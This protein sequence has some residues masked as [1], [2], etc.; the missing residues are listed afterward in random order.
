MLWQTVRQ[1]IFPHLNLVHVVSPAKVERHQLSCLYS[2]PSSTSILI[3]TALAKWSQHVHGT[4]KWPKTCFRSIVVSLVLDYSRQ[5]QRQHESSRE[6]RSTMKT[7]WCTWANG[8]GVMRGRMSIYGLKKDQELKKPCR[9]LE[10]VILS[11][12][13]DYERIPITNKVYKVSALTI[14]ASC[15][16][17]CGPQNPRAIAPIRALRHSTPRTIRPVMPCHFIID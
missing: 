13:E 5:T 12:A 7:V 8:Y 3:L 10:K 9:K 15:W 14:D 4:G 2:I 11:L 1:H 17:G 6:G 16:P